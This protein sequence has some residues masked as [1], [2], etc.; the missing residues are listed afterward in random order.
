MDGIKEMW[1]KC[2]G[3]DIVFTK[4][5]EGLWEATVPADLKDGTYVIEVSAETFTG[6]VV[7]KTAVLYLCDS[8][9]VSLELVNDDYT[10]Y[11]SPDDYDVTVEVL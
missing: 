7:Y 2:D 3:S 11:R 10:V 1:G 4:A 8:K 6:F 9:L 5:Q